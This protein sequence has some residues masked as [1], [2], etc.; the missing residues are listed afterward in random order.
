MKQKL[1]LIVLF[2]FLSYSF[3]TLN[4]SANENALFSNLEVGDYVVFGSFEQDNNSSNG[5]ESIEWYIAEVTEDHVTLFSQLALE[6]MPFHSVDEAVTWEDCTLRA[7]LNGEFYNTAFNAEE[8][9][10]IILSH[11]KNDMNHFYYVFGGEDTDD[12]VFIPSIEEIKDMG[13]VAGASSYAVSKGA[14]GATLGEE[15]V[16]PVYHLRSPGATENLNAHWFLFWLDAIGEKV[17]E[18]CAV[19]PVIRVRP[20]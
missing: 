16:L 19:V 7:W 4:V 9:N 15:V 5:T 14:H 3:R 17:N 18:A 20:D 11:N 1:P 8:K 12:Y 13:Y 2:L 10:H 6:V